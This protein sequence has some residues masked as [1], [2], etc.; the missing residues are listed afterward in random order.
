[1]RAPFHGQGRTDTT[2]RAFDM[3]CGGHFTQSASPLHDGANAVAIT[4][5]Q[6]EQ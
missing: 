4:H 1:M 6:G 5:M 2:A 3:P